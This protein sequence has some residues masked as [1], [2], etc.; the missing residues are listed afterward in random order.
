MGIVPKAI[1]MVKKPASGSSQGGS[2]SG[3]LLSAAQSA[4]SGGSAAGTLMTG[5]NQIIDTNTAD[6]K[7]VSAM[8]DTN[9]Y[10]AMAVQYNPSSL[11]FST[12][13]G[14]LRQPGVGDAGDN[15][16]TQV[17]VQG[18]T[19][20]SVQLIFEDINLKDAFMWEKYRLSIDDG[21]SAVQGIMSAK[22]G[23]Y[24][25]QKQV[26]GIL[27]LV[28]QTTTRQ[29]IFY[30][31][32]LSFHGELTNVSANYTMFNMTGNPIRA[33]LDLTI[34]Q[35]EA[36]TGASERQYWDKAFDKLFGTSD[37]NTVIDDQSALQKVGSLI[38]LNF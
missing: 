15:Q 26:D 28:T 34:R 24:S 36:E 35:G 18:K 38:N 33:Q 23:G 22:A 31:G 1:L 8:A 20:L 25:V 21:V 11:R 17:N 14:V 5:L 29:V 32:K 7:T 19:Q 6:F 12:A 9:G 10:Y 2:T 27:S 4:L 30:W 16:Y 3:S 13:A 37:Q